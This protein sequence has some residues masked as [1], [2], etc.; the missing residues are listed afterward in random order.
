MR[1][2]QTADELRETVALSAGEQ[3]ESAC[4]CSVGT[5]AGWE[6]VP[7]VRWPLAQ[8]QL[9]ATLRNPDHHEPTF[10]EFHP[11]GTRYESAQAP[12]AVAFYPYNRCDLWQCTRCQRHLLRY[13]E[14]GGYYID[15]RAR[16]L[17]VALIVK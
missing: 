9:L 12:V 17:H 11:G 13:T 1:L 2:I 16:A 10:E 8:M 3:T 5:C 14:F 6:S 7:D 4:G 15:H